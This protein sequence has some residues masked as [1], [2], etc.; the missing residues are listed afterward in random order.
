MTV[1][2]DDFVP[3]CTS[4]V[5]TDPPLRC[6]QAVGHALPHRID[7]DPV[8]TITWLEKAEVVMEKARNW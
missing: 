2:D 6:E 7:S 1:A 3:R 5:H 8:R 4:T